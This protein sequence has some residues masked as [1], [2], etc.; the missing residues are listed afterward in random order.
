MDGEATDLATLVHTIP[1]RLLLE[2]LELRKLAT[3]EH[4]SIEDLESELVKRCE[5]TVVITDVTIRHGPNSVPSMRIYGNIHHCYG[6]TQA[7]LAR[8]ATEI[9]RMN[10]KNCDDGGIIL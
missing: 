5:A 2:E 10:N 6:L 3:A 9:Q 4:L 8:L 1:N 7:M